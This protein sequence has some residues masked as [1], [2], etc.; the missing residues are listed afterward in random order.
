MYSRKLILS[1]LLIYATIGFGRVPNSQLIQL[2][3]AVCERIN[4]P[5][6]DGQI[7][8]PEHVAKD[9]YC[10]ARMLKAYA[11]KGAITIFGSA[12]TLETQEP[13]KITREFAA[14]WTQ[15][16]GS[17]YPI[18][19]GGGRGIMEAGN[20]GAADVKGLSLSIGTW[21]TGGLEKPNVYTTHGYMASSFAQR[22][23]DLVDY[24]A[25]VVIA[26]GGFG[27]EWEIYESLSK[28]QTKKKHAVPVI[29]LGGRA[30]WT[31][32]LTRVEDLKNQGTIHPDD[33]NLFQ[34]AETP[35]EAVEML[36]KRLLP[37]EAPASSQ[38]KPAPKG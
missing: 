35:A 38:P 21:F 23:A 6:P 25:A 12:R 3:P 24:A 16:A 30:A 28:I 37:Q 7:P 10:A 34:I 29:L 32:F 33:V 20:R 18:M 15:K 31:H 17:K 2:S 11:P 27:T 5:V 9:A 1:T 4:K 36:A 8:T 13:Y 14:L 19:T 26:P 22:E